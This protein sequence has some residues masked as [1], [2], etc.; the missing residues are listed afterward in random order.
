MILVFSFSQPQNTLLS[1]PHSAQCV[2][3]NL[4]SINFHP[5]VL[6]NTRFHCIFCCTKRDCGSYW[7]VGA[8]FTFLPL[9][10]SIF[11]EFPKNILLK[12]AFNCQFV[13]KWV[14]SGCAIAHPVHP[15]PLALMV[16]FP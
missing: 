7:K 9:T 3:S 6:S 8:Q 11:D 2:H 14:R 16:P 13:K 1:S 5:D 4:A 10:R 12:A 15:V